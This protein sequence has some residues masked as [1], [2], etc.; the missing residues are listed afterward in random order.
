MNKKLFIYALLVIGFVK[1]ECS[2]Q[3]YYGD[4]I[5]LSSGVR[6][7]YSPTNLRP[8]TTISNQTKPTA[9]PARSQ[10]FLDAYG[11]PKEEVPLSQEKRIESRANAKF[12]RAESAY[13]MRHRDKKLR[14]LWDELDRRRE[15][16]RG[17]VHRSLGMPAS[18]VPGR[19]WQGL[20]RAFPNPRGDLSTVR[21]WAGSKMSP[22]KEWMQNQTANTKWGWNYSRPSRD[23]DEYDMAALTA[24]YPPIEQAP[25]ENRDWRSYMPDRDFLSNS[26]ERMKTQMPDWPS[27]EKV[28]KWME[29]QYSNW[30]KAPYSRNLKAEDEAV[31]NRAFH[32]GYGKRWEQYRKRQKAKG[33]LASFEDFSKTH[34][35]QRMTKEEWE[36]LLSKSEASTEDE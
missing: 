20:N 19:A 15:A 11:A 5:G 34:H 4:E 31:L 26:W 33:Q 8:K 6:A 10:D 13:E 14:K 1:I 2:H 7:W 17:F 9:R 30:D 36:E 27:K 21:D 28:K 18:E 23:L 3:P 24:A 35:P 16:D 12:G 25:Q 29:S 32:D 22:M